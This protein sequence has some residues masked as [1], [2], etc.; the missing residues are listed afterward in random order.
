M[1]K[2]TKKFF[3]LKNLKSQF[4]EQAIFVLKEKTP[5]PDPCS[6]VVREAEKIIEG[7][8]EKLGYNPRATKKRP[9]SSMLVNIMV[10]LVV[11]AAVVLAA[12]F[13]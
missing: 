10:V 13:I 11:A 9:K 3:V 6:D 4:I 12:R 7:Y 5:D 8:L 1:F 2:K